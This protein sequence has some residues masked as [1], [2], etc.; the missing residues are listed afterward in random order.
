MEEWN[1]WNSGNREH[2]P[3]LWDSAQQS[4]REEYLFNISSPISRYST[5][6][7]G[8]KPKFQ[9]ALKKKIF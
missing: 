6:P 4:E 5:I 8:T 7:I 2:A 9:S 3:K 1:D